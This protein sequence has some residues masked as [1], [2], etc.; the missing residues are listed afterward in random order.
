MRR[1]IYFVFH[2]PDS[3]NIKRRKTHEKTT[4]QDPNTGYCSAVPVYPGSLS[5]SD[6]DDHNR[7]DE[8]PDRN[9]NNRRHHNGSAD[10]NPAA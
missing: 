8:G 7:N 1:S 5:G 3:R 4:A 2:L 6:N 9:D 10:D